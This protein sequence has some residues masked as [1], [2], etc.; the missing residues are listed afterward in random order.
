MTEI[1]A[2]E[3]LNKIIDIHEKT[4]ALK[5]ESEDNERYYTFNMT[6]S[7]YEDAEVHIGNSLFNGITKALNIDTK[8]KYFEDLPLAEIYFEYKG[9]R[10]LKVITAKKEG[11]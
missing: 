8:I 1:E 10:I 4:I 7:C 6:I 2:K 5:K 9:Y 11:E 3:A